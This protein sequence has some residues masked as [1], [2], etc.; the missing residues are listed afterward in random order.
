MPVVALASNIGWD[1]MCRTVLRLTRLAGWLAVSHGSN[2]VTFVT[3]GLLNAQNTITK[4][5]YVSM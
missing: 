5:E 2:Y 4:S 1:W 3:R